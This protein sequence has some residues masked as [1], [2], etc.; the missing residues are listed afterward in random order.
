MKLITSTFILAASVILPTPSFA[1]S[2][3]CGYDY[4]GNYNCNNSLR[5]SYTIRRNLLGQWEAIYSDGRGNS[6]FCRAYT[7]SLGR[8]GVNCY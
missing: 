1:Y 7:D 3:T 4:L 6:V 2:Q 8:T 5:S